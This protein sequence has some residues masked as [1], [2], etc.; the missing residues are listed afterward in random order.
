MYVCCILPQ[1][2][3]LSHVTLKPL[4]L[5][6]QQKFANY[7][8][9]KIEP[10]FKQITVVRTAIGTFQLTSGGQEDEKEDEEE[11]E[12]EEEEEAFNS[13]W[14]SIWANSVPFYLPYSLAFYRDLS[15]IYF[16]IL[17]STCSGILLGI[18]FG[19]LS[20]ICSGVGLAFYLFMFWQRAFYL[21]VYLASVLT[22]HLACFLA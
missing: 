13:T 3:T 19:I 20:G 16:G 22:L 15:G 18:Y 12:V 2:R 17:S 8:L 1:S 5:L 6:L 21:A 14:H 4:T 9:K 7:K 10:K 11:E